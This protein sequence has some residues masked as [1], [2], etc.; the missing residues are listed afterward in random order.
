[1]EQNDLASVARPGK[2]LAC[3]NTWGIGAK[4][5]INALGQL[6]VAAFSIFASL[7][8]SAR[9]APASIGTL[10]E[11]HALEVRATPIFFDRGNSGMRMVNVGK[12]L[13]IPTSA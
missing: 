2:R 7:P 1:M 10:A 6:A 4:G 12:N 8:G 9:G 3:R 5:T 11:V 13:D